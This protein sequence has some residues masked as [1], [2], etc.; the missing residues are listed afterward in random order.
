MLRYKSAALFFLGGSL[1]L[2]MVFALRSVDSGLRAQKQILGTTSAGLE[3]LD[4]GNPGPA[5]E[6]LKTAV[7][8]LQN[9]SETWGG[10][11]D[12][13]PV[14]LNAEEL[15]R[16]STL[17]LLALEA[18]GRGIERFEGSRLVWNQETNSSDQQFYLDLRAARQDLQQA[19]KNLEEATGLLERVNVG[20]LPGEF[21][22]KFVLA[23]RRL[24]EARQGL[25]QV[26]GLQSLLLNLLGGETKT[27][28]LLFQNNNEIRATGGFLGTYGLL[29][30]GNGRLRL[31]KIESIYDLDGQLKELVAAPGPLQ[32]QVASHWGIRD[33]NWFVDFPES[34]RKILGFLEKETGILAD[35]IIAFTPDV[36]EKLLALLGPVPMP[37]YAVELN[38]QNFRDIVQ[39]Q[40]SVAYDR[41]VNRPKQFLADFAPRFLG[42]L[43][44]LPSPKRLEIFD[45][46]SQL[47]SEKQLLLFSLDPT[48]ERE[49]ATYGVDGRIKK[50]D[51]DYLT[52]FHSNVGGGKTDIHIRQ[53]VEKK[54]SILSDG[55]A[56]VNLKI[57]RT[58]EGFAEQYFPKNLNFMRILVPGNAKLLKASGFDDSALPASEYPGAGT[59][60]DLLAWDKSFQRDEER[61]IYVG[62]EAGYRVFANWQELL[63]G[64]RKSVE[65]TY[66]VS[67]PNPRSYTLLLQKQ[68]GAGAYPFV[69]S[70]TYFPGRVAYA[71]PAEASRIEGREVR[72][73]E[74]IVSDRFYGVVGE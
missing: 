56:I 5:Y 27:Y 13:L 44:I 59:D 4:S 29:E 22:R 63:P 6:T 2:I 37:E 74:V 20:I 39:Y 70:V 61:K 28:L 50:S 48:L 46:L 55:L 69:L 38:A 14:G 1:L 49:F 43:S 25:K 71:T 11:L 40:T 67:L 9:T 16:L 60:A 32:R 30:F 12:T 66:E 18:A 10:I 72:Y 7:R 65:L 17:L 19:A 51:G 34:S 23:Q 45:I 53:E 64:E 26:A 21:G 31:L 15:K 35:G 47:A 24:L 58:H 57:T 54:V 52:I 33:S 41:T 3:L 42:Q 62:W 36:F 8:E 68:P 73:E